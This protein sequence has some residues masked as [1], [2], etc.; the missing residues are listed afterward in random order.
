MNASYGSKASLPPTLM[1]YTE[2]PYKPHVNLN[3]NKITHHGQRNSL[4]TPVQ[5]DLP[6]LVTFNYQSSSRLDLTL[7]ICQQEH[8]SAEPIQLTTPC[9]NT[10][11]LFGGITFLPV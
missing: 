7:P 4:Q 3:E 10:P 6:S 9:K 11:M 1:L 5:E 2:Q 8:V